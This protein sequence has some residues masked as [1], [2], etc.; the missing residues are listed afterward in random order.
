MSAIIKAIKKAWH[1]LTSMRTA[2]VLLFLLSLGAIPGAL[3]PQ[4]SL[5][6]GKVTE[7]IEN[8]GN[9]AKIYDK[10]QLFDV[11]NSSWFLA[12]FFLLFV[13]LIGC[14][15]PRTIDHYKAM[16]MPPVR[17]PKNLER[18]PLHEAGS[19]EKSQEQVEADIRRAFRRW[20]LAAYSPQ[21]DR[22]GVRS[23]AAERGYLREFFNLCFHL[24]IV[25]MLIAIAVGKLYSYEG[26]VIVVASEKDKMNTQ[27]CNT[28]TANYDSFKAGP[29]FDGTGLSPFCFEVHDFKADY[30]PNGQAKMYSSRIS[31]A[32]GDEINTDSATWKEFNLRVNHPLRIAGDRVYLQGH[33][34]A[35]TFTITWPNGQ[36]RTQTVQWRPDDLTYFLSSGAMRFD[37]PAGLYPDLYQRRQ[38]QLA[39]QGLFAPTA[40]W[41]GE[42]NELLSSRYPTMTDPAVAIDIYRGDNGLDTGVGQGLFTLDNSLIHSGQLQRLERVNLTKGQSVTLDD[43]T[44]VTFDGAEEFANYQISH[45]PA[46]GWILAWTLVSLVSLVGSLMIKRRRIWVRITPL[47]EHATYVETAGLARTDRAGWGEEYHRIH[48]TILGIDYEEQD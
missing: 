32:Q 29:T 35:P 14:I 39:I 40:Q 46:Q 8:N 3:L 15:I 20:H 18:L 31:Y 36:K 10:L 44:I 1:W 12:I 11:F 17:A 38:Q 25:G 13:S 27:F 43:G 7:Y 16:K 21:E 6:E 47:G 19:V 24:G 26:Q 30:L 5:N 23:F 2:L 4:R 34:F 45:N 9:V 22:A 48:C 33:G 28:A 42:N 41:S 37:P